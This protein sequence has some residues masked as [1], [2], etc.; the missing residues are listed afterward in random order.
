ML[1]SVINIAVDCGEP[2][3]ADENG[4]VSFTATIFESTA[5]YTC[6]SGYDLDGAESVTCL[7]SGEWSNT[8][9]ACN[10]KSLQYNI[11]NELSYPAWL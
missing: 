6:D 4:D 7:A 9:P 2:D 5:T 10:R 8:A 1:L 11:V 3:A